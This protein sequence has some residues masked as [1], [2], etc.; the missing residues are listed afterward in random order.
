MSKK[1]N[2]A[3]SD[4]EQWLE[5][6]GFNLRAVVDPSTFP[7]DLAAAW[8]RTGIPR[9]PSERLVLLGMGGP[10]LWEWMNVQ[11]PSDTHPFDEVSCRAVVEVC[12]RFWGDCIPKV[13]YPGEALI[14]L[15]QL[16]RFAGW[17]VPSPLGLDISPV[18]GPWFAF[19]A[20]FLIRSPLPLTDI[21]PA[22]SPCDTCQDMPCIQ[23]CP[24]EAVQREE[25]LDRERC[26]TQRFADQGGCGI[27]CYSRLACPIGIKWRYPQRQLHYHGQRSLQSLLAWK[28]S[29]AR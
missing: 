29:S 28:Q 6:R 10:G 17:S 27:Q 23:A 2:I 11:W 19:R 20:A 9:T 8:D 21:S 7:E 1:N 13:L 4:G 3:F 26:L 15:Q 14:P 25:A 5:D 18:Y 22:A 24:V 12:E 16:G